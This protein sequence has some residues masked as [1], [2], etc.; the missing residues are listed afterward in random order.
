MY[1]D[2]WV[3]G[4][5][6]YLR[7]QVFQEL[8]CHSQGGHSGVRATVKKSVRILLLPFNKTMLLKFG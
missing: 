1:K 8:H 4:R 2:K 7:K 3:I 6:G 5:N